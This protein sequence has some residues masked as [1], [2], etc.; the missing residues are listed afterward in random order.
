[1][2]FF[3]K[4]SAFI[5]TNI[6][7]DRCLNTPKFAS[8][9]RVSACTSRSGVIENCKFLPKLWKW[10]LEFK[11]GNRYFDTWLRVKIF[12]SIMLEYENVKFFSVW[13]G[14]KSSETAE[15]VQQM[16]ASYFPLSNWPNF[17]VM[18]PMDIL[19][20]FWYFLQ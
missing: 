19:A 3:L 4:Y 20:C 9:A 5:S 18:H 7:F 8:E 13:S 12:Q 1:M 14:V 6:I 15:K 16:S 2:H 11:S 17:K 10:R